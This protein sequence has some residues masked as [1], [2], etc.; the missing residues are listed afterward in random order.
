MPRDPPGPWGRLALER[1]IAYLQDL[2]EAARPFFP[3]LL[4]SWNG[5]TAGYEMPYYEDHQDAARRVLDGTFEQAEAD[6]LQDDLA[7]V[8]FDIVHEH[9]P[10][11]SPG[12]AT[13]LRDL[14][15]ETLRELETI[16][17]LEPAIN[18]PTIS[19][20]GV[21][22][23]GLRTALD[24]V[25]EGPLLGEMAAGPTVRLHGDLILENILVGPSLLLI[26]PV[27]V[28]GI[29]RGHPLFDLVKYESYAC[30]DLYAIREGVVEAGPDGDAFRFEIPLGH[31]ALAAFRRLDLTSRFREAHCQRHGPVDPRLYTLLDA[32]F[33]LVMARNVTGTHRWARILKAVLSLEKA[34]GR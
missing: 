20:N 7:K 25:L 12:M 5:S 4:S 23:S 6:A 13:H 28:A 14:L 17:E 11:S 32:Y 26:D 16:P 18:R 1:E 21:P 31:P 8:L 33:S 22:R 34:A 30:G 9:V 15:I 2:P 3:T 27:S 24:L 29:D 19:I 10:V